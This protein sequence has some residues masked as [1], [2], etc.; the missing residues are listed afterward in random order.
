MNKQ[1]LLL[2]SVAIFMFICG[3]LTNTI[4][5][6]TN[7]KTDLYYSGDIPETIKNQTLTSQN[8]QENINDQI[9]LDI[10]DR[11]SFYNIENQYVKPVIGNVFFAL[12]IDIV[13]KSSFNISGGGSD[14]HSTFQIITSDGYTIQAENT[15]SEAWKQNRLV[16]NVDYLSPNEKG[17]GWIVFSIPQNTSPKYLIFNINKYNSPHSLT[18]LG[19][20]KAPL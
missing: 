18:G 2:I 15:S 7:K 11:E 8:A 5:N 20:L 9:V 16:W 4:V 3:Y 19:R 6:M 13:N 1:K 12:H 14:Y 10:L 17:K